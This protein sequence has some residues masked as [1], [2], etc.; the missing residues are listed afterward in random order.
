MN[1]SLII[2]V[3]AMAATALGL[4]AVANAGNGSHL[5]SSYKAEKH[6]DLDGEGGVYTIKCNTG[7]IATDGMWR[8]DNVDQDNDY[9]YDTAPTGKPAWDVLN[10]VEPVAAYPGTVGNPTAIDTW[11]FK[12][13]PLAGGDVAG[14]L[15]LTCLPINVH[16]NKAHTHAW[17]PGPLHTRTIVAPGPV[18]ITT[19]A[20]TVYDQNADGMSCAPGETAIQPGFQWDDSLADAYGKPYMRTPVA[21]SARAWKWGFF[22]PTGGSV[23]LYW[24]CLERKTAFDQV[25]TPHHRHRLVSLY[26]G[27]TTDLGGTVFPPDAVTEAQVACGEHYKAML[28]SWNLGYEGY[29][30][31]A[32]DYTKKLWYLGMDP[33]PKVR[34]YK[35]LNTDPLA[36]FTSQPYPATPNFGAV[37]FK[38]RT[39]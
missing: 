29:A 22:T 34:A 8:I 14:K 38:D 7:D 1:R 19:Y 37:C 21:T 27:V 36:S 20:N 9:V 13:V 4:P 10:S 25:P 15:F 35:I 23:T 32:G 33:R 24:R 17:I 26:K 5:L 18:G 16:Q 30:W 3:A 11:S 39:S 2:A 12:F 31:G 28:G 6:I